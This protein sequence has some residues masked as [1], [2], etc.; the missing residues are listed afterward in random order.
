LPWSGD[1]S[2]TLKNSRPG[3]SPRAED[4]FD[5]HLL[6]IK[7]KFPVFNVTHSISQPVAISQPVT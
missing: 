7:Q 5:R 3:V 1:H 4:R 2:G 6:G